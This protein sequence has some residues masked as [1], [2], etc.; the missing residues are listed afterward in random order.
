MDY[1]TGLKWAKLV[2][3]D[4]ASPNSIK[5]VIIKD[6]IN[7][8]SQSK[9]VEHP[10]ADL[11][12][13]SSSENEHKS[14]SSE[15]S[16]KNA[17]N[18]DFW[19]SS[20]PHF[21][22]QIHHPEKDQYQLILHPTERSHSHSLDDA[23][24]SLHSFSAQSSSENP[25]TYSISTS[26]DISTRL[27]DLS[28]FLLD[29][30]NVFL[31]S[32]NP[33]NWDLLL[34]L[35]S[36][37]ISGESNIQDQQ[38]LMQS[39]RLKAATLMVDCVQ[40]NL[41]TQSLLLSHSPDFLRALVSRL[42]PSTGVINPTVISPLSALLRGPNVTFLSDFVGIHNGFKLL[43]DSYWLLHTYQGKRTEMMGLDSQQTQV[44]KQKIVDLIFDIL[45]LLK[46]DNVVIPMRPSL[47]SSPNAQK[48]SSNATE[49][50][51][52]GLRLHNLKPQ[53]SQFC[54]IFKNHFIQSRTSSS[55]SPSSLSTKNPYRKSIIEGL[56]IILPYCPSS[57]AAKTDTNGLELEQ[58]FRDQLQEVKVEL[59]A[60]N[61]DD[62]DWNEEIEK[63]NHLGRLLETEIQNSKK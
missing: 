19:D 39:I 61:L 13:I 5:N 30:E 7:G 34:R 44:A 41:Q 9:S 27:D 26:H 15:D 29:R 45:T 42:S 28:E 16:S 38:K 47:V 51:F 35:L 31:F 49:Q 40:N 10:H 14:S 3:P 56:P 22:S 17:Q 12:A 36:M 50:S 53:F 18:N 11:V 60:L 25:P 54:K 2:Q 1:E 37:Q 59:L 55:T 62:G 48:S 46:D 6:S 57:D 8:H 43:A 20:K 4:E 33:R 24:D 21:D 52:L 32:K 58:Q 63:L 23:V